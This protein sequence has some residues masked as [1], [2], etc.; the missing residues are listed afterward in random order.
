MTMDEEM[1]QSTEENEANLLDS[2]L[3]IDFEATENIAIP[4]KLVD[5]VIGQDEAVK[6]IKKA[7]IQRRN[8]LLI[9]RPGTGK[10]MLGQALAELLPREELQDI[11][12]LPNPKDAHHP[13]V[14]TVPSGEGRRIVEHYQLQSKKSE[15]IRSFLTI[16]IPLLILILFFLNCL[17]YIPFF[18][19]LLQLYHCPDSS[20]H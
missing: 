3:G 7:A 14:M 4:K 12:C 8:V 5:Q 16:G 9:G 17:S 19:Y 2:D 20:K 13:K 11:M 1:E 18:Q 15:S 6:A 10:S